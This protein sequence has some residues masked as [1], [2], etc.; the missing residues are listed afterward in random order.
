[1]SIERRKTPD[2]TTAG[3]IGQTDSRSSQRLTRT[4]R[5]PRRGPDHEVETGAFTG[6]SS[7]QFVSAGMPPDRGEDSG[8]FNWWNQMRPR[9]F[10]GFHRCLPAL[11]E[12]GN[13]LT[14]E[15]VIEFPT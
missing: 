6:V 13:D 10:A 12:A 2:G 8:S 5:R 1:M 9:F 15:H 4:A 11:T 14:V 3:R 7:D